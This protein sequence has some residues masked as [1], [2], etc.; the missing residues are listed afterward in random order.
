MEHIPD[1]TKVAK[2]MK[3]NI[4]WARAGRGEPYNYILLKEYNS[5]MTS[6]YTLLW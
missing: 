3:L 6:D 2:N 1:P 5:K 4:L